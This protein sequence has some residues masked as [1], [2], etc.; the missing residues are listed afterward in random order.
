MICDD[1]GADLQNSKISLDYFLKNYCIILNIIMLRSNYDSV[2]F[3]V[4]P[5]F[6]EKQKYN[7]S[8]FSL[9]NR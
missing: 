7:I 4:C 9:A 8:T 2:L 6:P 5:K 1:S 3:C